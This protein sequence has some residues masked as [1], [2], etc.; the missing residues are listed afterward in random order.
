MYNIKV[1][2]RGLSPLSFNQPPKALTPAGGRPT[3][4]E[5]AQEVE[6]RIYTN[7]NGVFIPRR[8]LKKVLLEGCTLANLKAKGNRSPLPI[9]GRRCPGC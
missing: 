3:E 1:H 2:V 4:E 7:G 8:W 6:E 9:P 5:R